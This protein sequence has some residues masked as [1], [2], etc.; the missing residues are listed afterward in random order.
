MKTRRA[1]DRPPISRRG[2]AG[3]FTLI[4]VVLVVLIIAIVA[5][6]AIPLLLR[7]QILSR[8]VAAIKTLRVIE[9]GEGLY[10]QANNAY[11]DLAAMG[12]AVPPFVDAVLATG[13]KGGYQFQIGGLPAAWHIFG[14]PVSYNTTGIRT[15]Y[16][17]MTGVVRATDIG[18]NPLPAAA[19]AATWPP[20]N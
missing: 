3:A 10:Y 13:T 19:V 16:L 2:G 14:V 7:S 20:V 18:A 5:T 6:I 8:E 4:E 1:N 11:A 15:F 9:Q 17:D 12:A